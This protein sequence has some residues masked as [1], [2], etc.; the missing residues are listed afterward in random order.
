[1]QHKMHDR[2]ST[3]ILSQ[4]LVGATD[5]SVMSMMKQTTTVPNLYI[6]AIV[7]TIGN[8]VLHCVSACNGGGNYGLTKI[9]IY[10][11]DNI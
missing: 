3:M 11:C 9:A 6:V 8:D 1:M 5:D 10:F 4:I 7:T 2:C